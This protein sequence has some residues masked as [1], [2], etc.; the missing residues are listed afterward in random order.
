MHR[1][2]RFIVVGLCVTGLAC[3][4]SRNAAQEAASAETPERPVRVHVV[5]HY[6]EPMEVIAVGAGITQRLGLVAPGLSADFVIPQSIVGSGK[7][8]FRG[9]PS[10]Y[11]QVVRT[12]PLLI[13][14]GN[15]VDFEIATNLI[16]S[17]ANARP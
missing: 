11:G 12:D 5:N 1:S 9:Q 7:V 8:E 17:R 13:R 10:G 3:S 4:H 16:G 15:V 2:W 14:P 6:K